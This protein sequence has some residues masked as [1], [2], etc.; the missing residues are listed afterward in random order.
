MHMIHKSTF[1]RDKCIDQFCLYTGIELTTASCF[2]FFSFT[3]VLLLLRNQEFAIHYIIPYHYIHCI[4]Y[5]LW[6][7]CDLDLR[8]YFIY[9]M[10]VLVH[11]NFGSIREREREGGGG[12][13]RRGFLLFVCSGFFQSSGVLCF[14]SLPLSLSLCLCVRLPFCL[15]AH[16]CSF[17]LPVVYVDDFVSYSNLTFWLKLCNV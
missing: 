6:A 14:L 16:F 9:Y 5:E 8:I 11:F 15:L 10:L 17:C 7:C 3:L 2:S 12:E 4:L 13:E 1:K